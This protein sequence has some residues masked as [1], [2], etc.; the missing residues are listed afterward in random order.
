MI[1]STTK[2]QLLVFVLI[3]LIGV[4]YVG[5]R[6]ARL[7]RLFYDSTYTVTAHYK[8]SG[9]IYVGGEV[10]Y[11]GVGVGQVTDMKVTRKGVDVIL[12]VNKS[13]DK[14]PADAIALVANR[15]AVGEQFV[16]I[17][18]QTDDGPY[19]KQ[20]SQIASAE[21]EIPISTTEILTNLDNL[22]QSV[23]QADLRTVVAESGAAF[24]DAGPSLGQIIDTSN[25]FINA[26]EANFDTTTALIRD[27]RTVLQTQVDKE[28]SIRSFTRDLQLFSG[29]VAANDKNLRS[30]IDNGS[31]TATELRTFLE[32]NRVNLGSLINN[33]VTTGEVT[34]KHLDGIRQILVIY[35][36]IVAGGF[37]VAK[38][39]KDGQYDAQFGFVLTQDG[40]VCNAGYDPG[41]VRP[42]QETSDK[43]M[44][45]DAGCSAGAGVNPRGAEKA[46]NGRSA[47]N[48]RPPVATYDESTGK[49]SWGTPAAGPPIAYDGGAAQLFGSDSWKWMLLQPSM[50]DPQE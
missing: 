41:E 26:A 17:Q 44:D 19:L 2:K 10:A 27:S 13:E 21:T 14:I 39:N 20:G 12:S 32:Q 33:L 35:P 7:D 48:Y 29:T 42:P 46:P 24:K 45:T 31:A 9:G 8:Q 49:V 47:T 3:T 40:P 22:V 18:P 43:P 25:S 4:S 36:Y 15:S 5:A 28:S 16:D 6:F 37:T 23:P 34:V 30:L 11:R 50:A 1:T 38:K